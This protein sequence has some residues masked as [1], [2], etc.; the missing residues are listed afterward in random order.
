MIVYDGIMDLL[1][2]ERWG[3]LGPTTLILMVGNQLGFDGCS[4]IVFWMVV[5][6]GLAFGIITC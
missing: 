1:R 4:L 3:E 2:Q 6:V 5:I